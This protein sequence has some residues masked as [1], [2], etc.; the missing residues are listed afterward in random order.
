MALAA[1]SKL[2][3]AGALKR[4]MSAMGQKR[5]SRLASGM[6]V[7]CQERAREQRVE[8]RVVISPET[9]SKP[10]TQHQGSSPIFH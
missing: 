8:R 10:K 9:S 5:T 2:G 7:K 3:A 4:S 6:S 1:T